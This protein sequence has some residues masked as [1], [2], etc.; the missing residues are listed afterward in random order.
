MPLLIY[1][2]SDEKYVVRVKTFLTESS[3]ATG[4]SQ[5]SNS[6]PLCA[7]YS[8][9]KKKSSKKRKAEA[10][11]TIL[12]YNLHY[13]PRIL[14]NDLRRQYPVMFTNVFNS[15]DFNF[16]QMFLETFCRPDLVNVLDS[17]GKLIVT[18]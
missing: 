3:L 10:A 16:V 5:P 2:Y 14:K 1:F 17:L 18:C 12:E 15:C 6:M 7:H 13:M 4:R 11:P 8:N 9:E